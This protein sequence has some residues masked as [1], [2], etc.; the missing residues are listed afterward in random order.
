[1]GIMFT[2][3]VDHT[4][5][6]ESVE[7]CGD[8]RL[9]IA[10]DF[11]SLVIG[12]SIAV[13]G[14]CLTVVEKTKKGFAADVS[15]ET[16]SRTASGQWEKG[17][18]VN[19]ERALKMG[20]ALSGHMVTGHIDGVAKLVD[21]KSSGDSQ[22]WQLEAPKELAKFIA[23]K[24]SVTLDGVSLTVNK[25]EARRFWVNIIPHTQSR[26]MF[27][28]RKPGDSLNLEIDILARYVERFA[29]K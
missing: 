4:G 12:E 26:T 25:V 28:A 3:I 15:A 16:L 29:Q 13:N 8:V 6:I 1:M 22:V 10:C 23:E 17:R 2:G 27:S 18:T 20:D 7:T 21:I 5:K 14:V 24:G 11:K 9:V 19:L